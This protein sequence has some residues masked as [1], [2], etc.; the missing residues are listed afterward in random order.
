[1]F[2][3]AD[4]DHHITKD[5]FQLREQELRE[6]LLAAQFALREAGKQSVLVVIAGVDAGGKGETVQQLESWLDPRHVHTRA[7]ADPTDEER[8]RPRFWRYWRELPPRGEIGVFF[9]SWYRDPIWQRA[10]GGLKGA[11]FDREMD[12]IRRFEQMLANEDVVLLKLWFHLSARDQR[13]RLRELQKDKRTRWRVSGQDWEHHARHGALVEVATRSLRLTSTDDAPWIIVPGKDERYRSLVV[14]QAMLDALH[15]E[16]VTAASADTAVHPV[17]PLDGRHVLQTIGAPRPISSKVYEDELLKWQGELA[18]LVRSKAFRK[19]SLV[20]VFEGV[21]AAGKGGAIR[22]LTA[23]IDPRSYDVIPIAAPT[24][25]EKAHP[26]LW[27]FWRRLPPRGKAVVF[28]RSWYGRVLVERVEGY[29]TARDWL[30]AYGEINDFE[31]QLHRHGTVIVKMWL[32][33][34]EDEQLRRFRA[35][36]EETI[37]KWKIGPDDWRNREKW[38]DYEIAVNDMVDRTSTEF[39]PW[40]LISA[41]DKH[42]ARIEVLR[43]VCERLAAELKT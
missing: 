32:H 40:S 9:D 16:K 17:P 43:T 13:E 33:I 36:E 20:V 23:A 27:R 34:D 12:A 26:Y 1:M 24:D 4:I 35:R 25:E 5:E 41:N 10:F 29:A 22:R 37:K 3:I 38:H 42:T 30:R 11:R 14:G 39:A 19:R 6:K 2:E 21:D 18:T 28:D 7:F 8:A 31:E 15:N